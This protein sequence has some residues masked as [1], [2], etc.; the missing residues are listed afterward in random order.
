MDPNDW[1]KDETSKSFYNPLNDEVSIEHYND[2]N[3][4]EMIVLQFTR[5]ET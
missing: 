4:V 1:K 2:N 5:T 3:E